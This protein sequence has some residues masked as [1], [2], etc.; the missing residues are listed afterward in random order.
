[1]AG[2]LPD[3]VPGPD[4]GAS[5][6]RSMHRLRLRTLWLGLLLAG[7]AFVV[8][9]LSN[10]SF[11]AGRGDL[12]YLADAFLHGRTWI[13]VALGPNDVILRGDHI[14]VPFAPFP[15][16]ALMPLVGVTG[17]ITADQWGSGINAGLAAAAVGL[18][19]WDSGVIGV[20]RLSDR[21]ALAL[22]L[23]FSTQFWWVSPRGGVWL[24]RH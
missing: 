14:Y 11:D 6:W 18:A 1:M 23:G 15:A 7:L 8:Y 24:P 4:P 20:R 17:P 21:L 2:I 5:T 3:R 9:W 12:F 16:L 22:L 13:T 10:R 19:W